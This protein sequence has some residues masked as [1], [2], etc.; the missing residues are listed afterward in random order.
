MHHT[1]DLKTANVI[2]QLRSFSDHQLEKLE[3][4]IARLKSERKSGAE[5][6]RASH[7]KARISQLEKAFGGPLR[8]KHPAVQPH[9][10][11]C[12]T[13]GKNV[14]D[15]FDEEAYLVQLEHALPRAGW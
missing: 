14:N 7:R 5:V 10:Q 8:C 9:S 1:Q 15:D 6:R 11:D 4:A 3:T 12:A 2:D 13:C